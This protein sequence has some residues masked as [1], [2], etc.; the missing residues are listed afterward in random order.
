MRTHNV[1]DIVDD[2]ATRLLPASLEARGVRVVHV[3][4]PDVDGGLRERRLPVASLPEALGDAASFCNVL[5]EWDVTD[6]VHGPGPFVGERI[7]ADPASLRGYPF[8]PEAA[9]VVADFAGPHRVTS[10]RELL[11]A[12]LA[13]ASALG[14]AVRAAFEFEWLVFDEDA[15][16]LRAKRYANLEAFAPDNRCWD[17]QSAAINAEVVAAQQA[18]LAAADIGVFGLGM[19]LGAGCMEATLAATEALRA[20]DDAVFFKLASRAFFRRRGQTACFMAQSDAAAPGLSGH[21]HLSLAAADGTNLFRGAPGEL[22]PLARH[23]TGGVLAL[24]PELIALPLHTVNAYRRLSPGNWAPRTPTWSF[25][26]YTTAVRAVAGDFP[27]ARLE[28]RIPGA[29]VNPYLGLAMYLAAGLWGIEHVVEP[30]PVA[31]GDGRVHAYPGMRQLPRDLMGAADALADSAAAHA[32][33][34]NGFVNAYVASRRHE[35][36]ALRRAVSAE[37]KARYFE[38]A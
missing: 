20:A 23:F 1:T 16:S 33:F 15:K 32:L 29:D 35:F 2:A 3:A 31:T 8:E 21:I 12:Q 6:T 4:I 11:K 34:G 22:T 5:H 19:E 36:D 25:G 18:M 9:W 27:S 10:P 38:I 26:G 7:E 37:E 13:R 28:F 30:P 14:Y 17:A 24:L